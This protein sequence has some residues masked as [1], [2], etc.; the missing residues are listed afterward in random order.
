MRRTQLA[1][2]TRESSGRR[3]ESFAR[4]SARAALGLSPTQAAEL[5]GAVGLKLLAEVEVV[6]P[7]GQN[8]IVAPLDER[9]A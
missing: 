3:D 5:Q 1:Q 4:P 9:P 7:D 8:T 6:V 2:T